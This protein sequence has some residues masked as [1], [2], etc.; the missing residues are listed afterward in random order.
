MCLMQHCADP[1][2]T[3]DLDYNTEFFLAQFMSGAQ[4]ADICVSTTNDSI[5]EPQEEFQLVITGFTP[6]DVSVVI[7]DPD[8]AT[9]IIYDRGG[10]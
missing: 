2:S 7:G 1:P 3:G 8:V 5:V 4:S 9:I 6:P 10:Q